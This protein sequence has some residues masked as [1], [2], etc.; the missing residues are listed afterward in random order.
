MFP[1]GTPSAHAQNPL[2]MPFK[3]KKYITVTD[4]QPK[5]PKT[6]WFGG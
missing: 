6:L 4:F 1:S 3:T 2:D 5:I